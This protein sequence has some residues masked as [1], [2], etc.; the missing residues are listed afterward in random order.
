MA[1]SEPKMKDMKTSQS[2]GA[3]IMRSVWLIACCCLLGCTEMVS[4]KSLDPTFIEI[5]RPVYHFRH[6]MWSGIF[7]VYGGFMDDPHFIAS[8]P[9]L[10][11][12]AVR[13][14]LG[15]ANARYQIYDINPFFED[16]TS[17]TVLVIESRGTSYEYTVQTKE[18]LALNAIDFEY[19]AIRM[20]MYDSNIGL[21]SLSRVVG[22]ASISLP[23]AS[24][25]QI[26]FQDFD[27][28][29]A[30]EMLQYLK[31]DQNFLMLKQ[32]CDRP[33]RNQLK[34]KFY[35]KEFGPCT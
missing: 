8:P 34:V 5:R 33:K 22:F 12:D 7:P 15:D 11:P 35:E 4:T 24:G 28:S 9:V 31:T 3:R 19:P 16:E 21:I 26:I 23:L 18:P 29:Y 30:R 32:L 10:L 6:W 20:F 27:T 13:Q 17:Q 2:A 1:E 14:I 25:G